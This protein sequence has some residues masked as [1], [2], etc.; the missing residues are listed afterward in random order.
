MTK[1]NYK[2]LLLLYFTNFML[3][4]ANIEKKNSC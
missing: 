2:I 4:L 1:L 3:K